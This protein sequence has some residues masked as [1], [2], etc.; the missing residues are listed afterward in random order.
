MNMKILSYTTTFW[1]LILLC[2]SNA[3]SQKED[4]LGWREARWGMSGKEIADAFK[5]EVKAVTDH[6]PLSGDYYVD[7]AIPNY[8]LNGRMFT[9]FFQMDSKTKKLAQILIKANQGQIVH[10]DS[11]NFL[12]LE[13][14]LRSKYGVPGYKKDDL[15]AQETGPIT[16]ERRWIFS[17]S[18]IELGYAWLQK[19]SGWL[20]IRYFPS[21]N[22]RI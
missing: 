17:T 20:Y 2:L 12:L 22:D 15:E 9:V 8:E 19:Q 14:S 4:V 7:Y 3:Y 5:G 21:R 1:V 16:R 18:T 10:L 11:E 13:A 6:H